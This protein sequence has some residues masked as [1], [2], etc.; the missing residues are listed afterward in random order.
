[1]E[2]VITRFWEDLMARPSGPM[3]FRFLL[4]PIMAMIFG[5]RD[6][7][8]DTRK[9]RP[10]FVWSILTDPDERPALLKD[11][12]RSVSKILLFALVLD[13][14]YQLMTFKRIYPMEAIVVAMAVA[15]LPYIVIRGV[16]GWFG[17]L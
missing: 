10:A 11:A 6:G 7:R 13:G 8:K 16:T 3:S 14:I 9:S 12:L 1:V 5:I 4:Q 2:D 17:R 15:L